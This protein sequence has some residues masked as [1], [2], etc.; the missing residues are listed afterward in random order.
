MLKS[1]DTQGKVYG[2]NHIAQCGTS[3]W[4]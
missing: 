3:D 2:W 1:L 4:T